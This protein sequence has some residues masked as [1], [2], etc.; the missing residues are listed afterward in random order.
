MQNIDSRVNDADYYS[1]SGE[2]VCACEG[3]LW[4]A[5]S[6]RPDLGDRIIQS[7]LEISLVMNMLNTFQ[8]CELF[9]PGERNLS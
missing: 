2:L 4:V 6:I 8:F 3:E 9:K 7:R 1:R 5:Y